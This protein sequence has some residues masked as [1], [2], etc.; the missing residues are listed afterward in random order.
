MYVGWPSLTLLAYWS[1]SDDRRYVL[2][3]HVA[4]LYL[5]APSVIVYYDMAIKTGKKKEKGA[6]KVLLF[7]IKE[8]KSLTR[9][10]RQVFY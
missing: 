6:R 1:D 3:A 8:L 5:L 7:V 9:T 10:F 2:V 4:R